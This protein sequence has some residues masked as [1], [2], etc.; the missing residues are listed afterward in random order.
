MKKVINL[1]FLGVATVFLS[2]ASASFL[3]ITTWTWWWISNI[4]HFAGGIYAFFLARAIF[5]STE[6]YHRTQA[7]FLMEIVIFILGALAVGV[8]WEWYEL[9]VDRYN[10]FIR[11]KASIMTYA[12]NIGDLITDFLG[13]LTAGIYLAF[14]R[15]RE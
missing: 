11:H 5:R 7:L 13:A 4:F 12:D 3:D 15:K 6:R 8:L 1:L 2:Y 14:K 9:A 10:I